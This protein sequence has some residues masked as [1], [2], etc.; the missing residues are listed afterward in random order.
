MNDG[1]YYGRE[2]VG[3]IPTLRRGRVVW[4]AAA[5][6]AMAAAAVAA[7]R[8][9]SPEPTHAGEPAPAMAVTMAR[10][11]RAVWP[12]IVP[13][14]GTI[15]AWQE[16]SIG[17]QVG[18]YRLVAVLVNVGDQVGKG[19][20]LARFDS[21]LLEAENERLAATVE[22]ATAN[23]QRMLRLQKSDA[24]SDRDVL[25]AVTEAKTAAAMLAANR[26]QLSYTEV[27]ASDDGVISA[28][29][30]TLGAVIPV[31]QELFRL[32][33]QNRL[34]WRGEL[35]AAQLA[36]V[37]I[38]QQVEL[39]LPGGGKASATMRQTAPSLDP[40]T[41]LGIVYA[42]IA[43]GSPARAGMYADGRV[44]V[45]QSDALVVPAESVTIRDGRSY[46]LTVAEAGAAK[47]SRRLVAIGRRRAKQVEILDGVTLG[48][49][50]VTAGV[51]FLNEGDIVRVMDNAGRAAESP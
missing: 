16:A 24:V 43:P 44:I 17:A 41:R 35:T 27:V 19:Q 29:T 38:G 48:D 46:V 1:F 36:H 28:R 32:I 39:I 42:D 23:A 31:G 18:G 50:L 47:V 51:G 2:G 11:T 26:L 21:A 9:P 22:E 5:I 6:A 34:E 15:A 14:S 30:A 40:Q 20:V 33:R 4:I 10:P 7:L 3:L 13:A 8:P 45:G 49:R 25:R 12:M 37:A